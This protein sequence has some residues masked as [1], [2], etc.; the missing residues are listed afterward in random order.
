MKDYVLTYFLRQTRNDSNYLANIVEITGI[1][2]HVFFSKISRK[3]R[4]TKKG[5]SFYTMLWTLIHYSAV[6]NSRACTAINLG[7]KIHPTFSY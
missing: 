7:V 4:F 6:S 1:L 5:T 3:Q 2:S